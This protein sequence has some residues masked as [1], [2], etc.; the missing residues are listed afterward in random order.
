MSLPRTADR[1]GSR[2]YSTRPGRIATAPK[3][4][5]P[6]GRWNGCRRACPPGCCGRDWSMP[7]PVM[8]NSPATSSRARRI[9][10]LRPP[11]QARYHSRYFADDINSA[12]VRVP[13]AMI[14]NVRAEYRLGRV[15]VFGYARNLFDRFALLDRFDNETASAEDPRMIGIGMEAPF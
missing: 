7:A 15:T 6:G 9:S 5:S 2:T 13:G 8:R 12:D 3:P 4:S 1:S 11:P 10:A 14:V